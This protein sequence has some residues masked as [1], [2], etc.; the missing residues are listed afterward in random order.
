MERA[1]QSPQMQNWFEWL[2]RLGGERPVWMPPA[3]EVTAPVDLWRFE[4]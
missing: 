2:R 3:I 1:L 4:L